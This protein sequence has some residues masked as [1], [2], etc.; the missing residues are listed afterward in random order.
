MGAGKGGSIIEMDGWE[1]RPGQ[2]VVQKEGHVRKFPGVPVLWSRE[3]RVW[4]FAHLWGQS[5]NK[6]YFFAGDS[7]LALATRGSCSGDSMND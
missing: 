6:G 2:Q 4:R 5:L 7:S 3:K 1:T